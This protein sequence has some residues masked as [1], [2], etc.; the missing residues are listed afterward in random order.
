MLAA[1]SAGCSSGDAAAATSFSGAAA[2]LALKGEG[3]AADGAAAAAVSRLPA[4]WR[5]MACARSPPISA[6]KSTGWKRDAGGCGA[7]KP[8]DV[9]DGNADSRRL[10]AGLAPSEGELSMSDASRLRDE[11]AKAE[12]AG[13]EYSGQGYDLI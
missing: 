10:W 5:Y 4:S 3:A 7:A 6:E 12:P 1:R 13:A 2:I 11:E 9:A 8:A